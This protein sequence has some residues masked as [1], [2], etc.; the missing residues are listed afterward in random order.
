M[1]VRKRWL[2]LVMLAII[3]GCGES[4]GPD[5]YAGTYTLQTI[6]G[7]DLPRAVPV[8]SDCLVFL[9]QNVCDRTTRIEV[10][11]GWLRLNSD[12]TFRIQTS[13]RRLELGGAQFDT[14]PE[15]T[16][17]W[18]VSGQ[19]LSL[20]DSQGTV[21]DGTIVDKT[22]TIPLTVSADWAYEK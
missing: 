8:L 19:Q 12:N 9:P 11:D 16:G 10:R 7:L 6:G 20:E 14:T 22:A 21:R 15:V 18:S 5:A 17:T 4:T 1:R 2:P 3:A 13:I